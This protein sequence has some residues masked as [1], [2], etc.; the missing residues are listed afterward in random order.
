MNIDNTANTTSDQ[1]LTRKKKCHGNRSDQRFR[2]RCRNQKKSEEEIEQLI[3][4]RINA[5]KTNPPYQ[6]VAN[7]QQTNTTVSNISIRHEVPLNENRTTVSSTNIKSKKRKRDIIPKE[8]TYNVPK[9]ASTLSVL[10]PQSGYLRA[11]WQALMNTL[12]KHLNHPLK[13]RNEQKFIYS[14]LHLFDEEFALDLDR[15]LWQSYLDIGLQQQQLQ[16]WP[17]DVY[18]AA[19]TNESNLCKQHL[20]KSLNE[21]KAHLDLCYAKLN[22]QAQS[23]LSTLPSLDILDHNLKRFVRQQKKHLSNR[24]NKQLKQYKDV[25]EE[26]ISLQ[27]ISLYLTPNDQILVDELINLQ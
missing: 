4:Q 15:Y 12:R 22:T 17:N 8:K 11:S 7:R 9:S 27:Q 20:V 3:N 19:K 6:A 23:W 1:Q 26:K 18:I 16:V 25:L 13:K 21:T 2:K 5:R 10:Q 14:R 24:I